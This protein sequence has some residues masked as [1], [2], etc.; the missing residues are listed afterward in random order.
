MPNF[1]NGNMFYS[2]NIGPAHIISFSSEVYFEPNTRIVTKDFTQIKEQFNWLV[3]D[4]I[5]A[6]LYKNRKERPWIITMAH[7]PL[8]CSNLGYDACTWK[9]NPMRE[10][11]LYEG[12]LR[13]GLDA[14]FYNYNV[15]LELWGHEHTYERSYPLYRH[16]PY[17][18][19]IKR[20]N[21]TDYYHN[22]LAPV[23]IISGSPG[24]K[25]MNGLPVNFTK[26]DWSAVKSSAYGFSH[27]EIHNNTHLHISQ[28]NSKTGDLI[29]N[30]WIIK[31][32]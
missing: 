6:N 28:V 17:F 8:Y 3:K 29:D 27:M 5:E 26:N 24:N 1:S 7:R 4:L 31:D 32:L 18:K 15:D 11:M 2:W 25:E 19:N 21:G 23:H 30:F 22:P 14:L 9:V 13:Y 16:T 20:I 12:K 10:G